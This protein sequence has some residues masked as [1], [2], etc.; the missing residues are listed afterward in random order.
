MAGKGHNRRPYDRD[1]YDDGFDQINW[2]SKRRRKGRAG[3]VMRDKTKYDR[4]RLSPPNQ[5]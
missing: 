5:D 3:Q 4:K 1:K 2:A